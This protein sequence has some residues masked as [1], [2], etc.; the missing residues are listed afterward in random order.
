MTME[1]VLR[2]SDG[3]VAELIRPDTA[4]VI[5]LATA[6]RED[7]AGWYLAAVDWK[8]QADAAISIAGQAFAYLSDKETTLSVNVD[9]Y[10]VSVPGGQ[11]KFVLD[12]AALRGALD[13]LVASGDISAKAADDACEPQGV[14][15]PGCDTFIPTGGY[16]VSQRALNALRKQPKLAAIIDACGEYVTPTSRP[17]SATRA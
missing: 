7:I 2:G 1:L 8:R 9:G 11:D 14:R 3:M 4:E 5:D 6:T 17:L 13:E 15:C 16:K 12:N 10:R